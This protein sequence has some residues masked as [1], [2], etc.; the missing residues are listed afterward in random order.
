MNTLLPLC[1][2]MT[3]HNNKRKLVQRSSQQIPAEVYLNLKNSFPSMDKNSHIGIEKAKRRMKLN[4]I[5]KKKRNCVME[6]A[7]HIRHF[8][9]Q[10]IWPSTEKGEN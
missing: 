3:T 7:S 1:S 4:N 5:Q 2:E 9:S 10:V 8:Q 6:N